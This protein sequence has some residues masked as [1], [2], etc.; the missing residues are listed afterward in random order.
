MGAYLGRSRKVMF[1]TR[2]KQTALATAA[3][4]D[5]LIRVSSGPGGQDAEVEDD[6]DLVGGE[7]EPTTQELSVRRYNLPLEQSKVKPST[8]AFVLSAALGTHTHTT[9]GGADKSRLHYIVPNTSSTDF[10]TFTTEELFATGSQQK[11][12]GCFADSFAL[13]GTRRNFFSLSGQVYGS[14]KQATGTASESE[15]SE[16]S[17]HT[18]DAVVF[19]H[20]SYG[21][22]TPSQDKTATDLGG[23]S[24][25]ASSVEEITWNFAN[26]TD[27]DFLPHFNSG[28]TA[29]R[30]ERGTRS[31]TLSMRLLFSDLTHVNYMLNQ[32]SV[33][34]EL[35]CVSTTAVAGIAGQKIL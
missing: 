21:G 13:T 2:T 12:I 8:L 33:A 16:V 9:P 31:Q 5:A 30:A 17:M 14:G 7:E 23:G 25:I 28:V 15:V 4:V 26:N 34:I 19:L 6:S 20:T 1:S 3:T 22:A 11:F 29:G 24:D 10:E 32:T 27:L 35:L 18:R